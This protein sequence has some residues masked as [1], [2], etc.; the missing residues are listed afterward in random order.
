MIELVKQGDEY[1]CIA[2]ND[3]ISCQII[4]A[5]R[6]T[7]GFLQGFAVTIIRG[8]NAWVSV[9]RDYELF[10][11]EEQAKKKLVEQHEAKIEKHQGYIEVLENNIRGLEDDI[12]ATTKHN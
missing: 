1:W 10:K 2:G 12:R 7:E 3:V 6:D 11:T 5:A 8:E 4:D 9:L